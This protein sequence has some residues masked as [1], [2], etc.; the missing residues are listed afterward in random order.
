MSKPPDQIKPGQQYEN[1]T[2]YQILFVEPSKEEN[3]RESLN[4]TTSIL[5]K[6]RG[7]VSQNEQISENAQMQNA[8]P[9]SFDNFELDR[10]TIEKLKDYPRQGDEHKLSSYLPSPGVI[11]PDGFMKALSDP[12]SQKIEQTELGNFYQP[13]RSILYSRKISQLIA[14]TWW[15]YLE[16]KEKGLWC[17]FTAGKW[18]N[19]IKSKDVNGF[20]IL[21]GLIAREIFLFGGGNPPN[22]P[23]SEADTIY[24]RQLT[25][26]PVE[27][28]RFL[29]LPSSKS[30][31]GISL[32]LL[33]AGQAYY[34]IEDKYHQISQPILS[35][36]E[37]VSKYSLEVD[38]NRFNGDIKEII[39]SQEK[40]WV[41]YH[42][43][44]PY[45]PI[46][47]DADQKNIGKWANAEDDGGELPF[48][49][50]TEDKKDYL[51]DV[52]YLRSPYPYIPLS[53]S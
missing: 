22:N 19:I 21:D 44:I 6:T 15:S 40:P 20:Y 30:W 36:G 3:K 5:A 25:R 23:Y 43:V 35:T 24:L 16:A 46:P 51:I 32:A 13:I 8:H 29:I 14:K 48:Y 12:E 10:E 2:Y 11:F 41:A 37:I 39:I 17:E 18:D 50:K 33:L 49:V 9:S 31:Q 53:C 52:D 4:L 26:E 27:Q 42:T 34:K 28:A 7:S 47:D 45:P 1:T 38:W